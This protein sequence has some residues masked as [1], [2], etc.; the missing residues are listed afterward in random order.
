[1]KY[2]IGIDGGGTKTEA[3]AYDL[4]GIEAGRG[5][6]GFSN[7]LLGEIAALNNISDSIAA[8]MTM[9][10]EKDNEAEF[11]FIYLGLAGSEA[12]DN[13]EKV[14]KEILNRFNI[15]SFVSNDAD[16]ALAALLNGEDGILTISGTGSISYGVYYEKSARAGGWGHLLGDEGSG[17]YIAIEA[18][19]RMILEEDTMLEKSDLTKRLMAEL[20][21]NEVEEIK[22]FIYSST[23]ADIA[24]LTPII[25]EA[26]EL[27]E[28]NAINILK[29]AGRKLASSTE[30][31]YRKLGFSGSVKVGIKG[32]ILTKVKIVKD[33]F[34]KSLRENMNE[35]EIID[36]DVSPAKGAF[37]LGLRLYEANL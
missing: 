37:Y 10:R 15:E 8:C 32:S 9:V 16:I 3:I 25:V 26:A 29:D 33:E 14:K 11:V 30:M 18:F 27:S 5:Y 1:M 2:I 7:L 28:V 4:N 22:S 34:K 35:A 23:K 13:K 12:G 19:K 36:R 17:Y 31:V 21:I 6:G 20:K 24:A